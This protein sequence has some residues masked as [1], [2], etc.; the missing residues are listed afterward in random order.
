M[1]VCLPWKKGGIPIVKG[2]ETRCLGASVCRDVRLKPDTTID[3]PPEGGHYV[4]STSPVGALP[5]IGS[6][7]SNAYSISRSRS[8]S[9]SVGCGGAGGGGGFRLRSF[10]ATAGQAVRRE[11]LLRDQGLGVPH[12]LERS[13]LSARRIPPR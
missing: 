8:R 13:T 9:S 1:K 12:I 4:Y 10:G 2:T 3:G 11:H 6:S 7:T 5:A